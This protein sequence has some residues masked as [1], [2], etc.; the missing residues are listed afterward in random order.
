MSDDSI[1][2]SHIRV[3]TNR[4]SRVYNPELHCYCSDCEDFR[5]SQIVPGTLCQPCVY[6]DYVGM[7]YWNA[8]ET[9][10]L[11]GLTI[12]KFSIYEHITLLCISCTST[13]YPNNVILLRE[14]GTM[15]KLIA[16]SSRWLIRLI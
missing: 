1:T 10:G 8:N 5:V 9:P 16:T 12:N 6:I 15:S 4:L 14:S 7:P 3:N 11:D 13:D 2:T